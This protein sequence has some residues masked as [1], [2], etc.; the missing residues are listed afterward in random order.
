[1]MIITSSGKDIAQATM[2]K[3]HFILNCAVKNIF[4]SIYSKMIMIKSASVKPIVISDLKTIINHVM[5]FIVFKI[6]ITMCTSQ[7]QDA[8]KSFQESI[9][10]FTVITKIFF[11][12]KYGQPISRSQQL[13]YHAWFSGLSYI[14]SDFPLLWTTSHGTWE[15]LLPLISQYALKFLKRSF[16]NS[17][18][19][20]KKNIPFSN[21]VK[22]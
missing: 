3:N 20:K 16:M 19:T 1:M 6:S 11:L 15:P 7:E 14:M 10:S 2:M 8:C 13:Y 4:I 5:I 17:K 21:M 12:I 22:N 18:W 9:S